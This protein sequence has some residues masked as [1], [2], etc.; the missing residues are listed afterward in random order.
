[1][2]GKE[3][4]RAGLEDGDDKAKFIRRQRLREDLK[5]SHKR[6]KSARGAGFRAGTDRVTIIDD[7]S[8]L[9]EIM[10]RADMEKVLMDANKIKFT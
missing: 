1:M 5:D 2:D 9:I 10:G 4:N 6:I 3:G 7:N 8:N